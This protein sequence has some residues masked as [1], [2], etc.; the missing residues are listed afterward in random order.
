MFVQSL[1]G[2]SHNRAEDTKRE[3][4]EQAVVAMNRLTELTI[5]WILRP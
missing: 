4:L 1:N 3:H 5:D 2:L